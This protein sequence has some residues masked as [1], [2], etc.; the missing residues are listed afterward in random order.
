MGSPGEANPT[1]DVSQTPA[2]HR[3]RFLV[4]GRILGP[5]GL[6]GTVRAQ[7]LTDFPERFDQL[8]TVHIGDSLRP[9]TVLSAR[10]EHQTVL[11][12]LAGVED[13][14]AARAL[15]NQDLQ[16]PIAEAAPLGPD[17]FFWHQIIGLEV[18]TDEGRNLG[19]VTD[20][21]RTGSNDVY[22]VGEG[23]QALL[24]PAIEDVIRE[25]DLAQH[26]LTVHLLPGL[27]DEA[28]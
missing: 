21:L 9:Y 19:R 10:P 26:R 5:V 25:V 27:V 22:V 12:K 13:A 16:I 17:Q 15:M 20:V 7:M 6:T 11:L 1:R 8:Q 24:L 4:V 2:G 3:V 28:P 14:E 23:A 18:W